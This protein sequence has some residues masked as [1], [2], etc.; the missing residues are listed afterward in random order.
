M[1]SASLG[2]LGSQVLDRNLVHA[3]FLDLA[4]HR[5]RK[6]IHEL[7]V[8]GGLEVGDTPL[9]PGLQFK[10]VGHMVGWNLTQATIS[11]P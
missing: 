3:E 1:G 10:L 4:R 7:E 2:R 8:F 11:S 5:H 9:A 6:F